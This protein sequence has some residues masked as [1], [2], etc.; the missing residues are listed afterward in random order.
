MRGG[1]VEAQKAQ[2]VGGCRVARGVD[3]QPVVGTLRL[4]PDL[5]VHIEIT[6]GRMTQPHP[7]HRT[8]GREAEV[9]GVN[10][11]EAGPVAVQVPRERVEKEHPGHGRPSDGIIR[12]V[13][14]DVLG[15]QR[16]SGAVPGE[17][18][19][20]AAEEHGGGELA[21]LGAESG[22]RVKAAFVAGFHAAVMVAGVLHVVLGVCALRLLPETES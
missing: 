6:D 20:S 8:V 14:G 16:V 12:C 11:S 17:D 2:H 19:A 13:E 10:T 21:G 15:R 22:H 3:L 18:V 4:E 1:G 7:A 5:V 9:G